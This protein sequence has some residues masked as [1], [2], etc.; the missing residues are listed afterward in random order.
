MSEARYLYCIAQGKDGKDF[1]K[2]VEGEEVRLIGENGLVAVVHNC[3]SKPYETEDEERAKR[4]VKQH[5]EVVEKVD[6][7]FGPVVPFGFDQIFKEEENLRDFLKAN[8]EKIRKKLEELEGKEEFGITIFYEK[9]L[10]EDLR[11]E[12]EREIGEDDGEEMS[13]GKKYFHQKKLDRKAKEKLE[14]K[15][16][17]Y[18]K[19]FYKK[20]KKPSTSVRSEDTKEARE[21]G[22]FS[23]LIPTEKIE[24]LSSILDKID[25][26]EGFKV[27]FTGPWPPYS[28]VK[29]LVG[30]SHGA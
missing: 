16:K 3:E 28:F 8:E 27:R 17:E 20:V 22:R 18:F 21:L 11:E 29:D 9:E 25:G 1:G 5:Q 30:E 13:K 24:Q 7:E 4:W 14:E 26:R 2:G 12:I 23:C 15:L 19:Q 10:E 6:D